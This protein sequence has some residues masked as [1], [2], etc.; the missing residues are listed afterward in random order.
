VILDHPPEEGRPF[1]AALDAADDRLGVSLA[2]AHARTLTPKDA[3]GNARRV[4]TLS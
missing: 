1:T 3:N 2:S 4:L